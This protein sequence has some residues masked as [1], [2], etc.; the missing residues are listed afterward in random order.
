MNRKM[1]KL[2]KVRRLAVACRTDPT[3]TRRQRVKAVKWLSRLVLRCGGLL[4]DDN[5][6]P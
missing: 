1:S 6:I 3:A 2:E 5:S 4:L